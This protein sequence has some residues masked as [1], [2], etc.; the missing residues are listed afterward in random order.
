MS[1]NVSEQFNSKDTMNNTI[2]NSHEISVL[3]VRFWALG[4]VLQSAAEARNFK[5]RFPNAH[6]TFLTMPAYAELLRMQPYIDDVIAG[7]KKP[8][9]EF[10]RTLKTIKS[11]NFDAM[12]STN[13]G[14]KT[15]LMGLCSG[16]KNRIGRCPAQ[17][18]YHH[19]LSKWM[20]EMGVDLADRSE[21]SIFSSDESRICASKILKKLERKRLLAI[22]GASSPNRMW[23]L[24]NWEKLLTGLVADGWDIVLSGS[25]RLEEDFAAALLSTLPEQNIINTAGKLSL[26]ELSGAASLCSACIGNDTGTLHLA[27]L[28]GVPTIG[29]SDYDQYESL[30]FRMPRFIGLSSMGKPKHKIN[31]NR[32]R[33]YEFLNLISPEKVAHE[34]RVLMEKYGKKESE[35]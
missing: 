24:Q 8:W 10:W 25:G 14:G 34:L 30:G 1:C 18:L 20:T 9:S 5:K 23:S 4:D 31:S 12:I 15:A 33:S 7:N 11:K 27:A 17:F 28:S 29:L 19:E 21:R 35:F 22:V 32:G 3:W 2:Q 6:V 13:H 26:S 16:I